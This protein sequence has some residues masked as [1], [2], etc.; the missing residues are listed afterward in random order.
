MLP[1][2]SFVVPVYNEEE[3]ITI[4]YKR[5]STV[6]AQ[7]DG[8]TEILFV[9]DGSK[10]QSLA[11]IK[12]LQQHD[13]S[14]LYISLARN[15]GHQIAITAG[16]NY[17]KGQAVIILDADLQDPPELIPAMIEKW[18]EG[19]QVIY[20]ERTYR[21]S[22][23]RLKRFTAYVFYRLLKR[24]AEVEIPEDSGDFCLLDRKIV[25]ILNS[26]PESNRYIR[27]LR[28]WAGFNQTSIQYERDSRNAGKAKYTF[29]KSF[30]LA[31]NGVFSF[32]KVPLRF[33]TYL[34]IISA[35]A[36]I[37]MAFVVLYWR[38][39]QPNSP[40]DGYA[41]ILIVVFFIG[42]IQLIS[43]GIVGEYIGRIYEEVKRR[44]L[45][46]I[47]ELG[48]FTEMKANLAQPY[49]HDAA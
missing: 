25:D 35:I 13:K 28:A 3:N 41:T 42:A 21:H 2:Y 49:V 10:D 45:Y 40:V 34:G 16:L 18:K 31:M 26:I 30:A 8:K 15:F 20:A 37:V 32:S 17:V 48:G 12:A 27:G 11:K 19:N 24:L 29:R 5:L 14:V 22:E 4:L 43:V 36:S 23:S 1:K 39:F 44:P 7:L 38:I 33:S 9:N 46:T 6:I 47:S